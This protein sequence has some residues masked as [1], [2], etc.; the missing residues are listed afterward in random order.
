MECEFIRNFLEPYAAGQASAREA[1][2]V[3]EHVKACPACGRE[4]GWIRGLKA[5][6]RAAPRPAIP[7]DLRAQLMRQARSMAGAARRPAAR[8][9][10]RAAIGF[11][12]ASAF[13]AAAAVL[14]FGHFFSGGAD[15]LSLDEVLTAH[16]RYE[17]TM[18]AADREAIYADLGLGEGKGGD[19]D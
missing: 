16:R 13:A 3:E 12:F 5:S 14:A 8:E 19:D 4:L 7:D 15:E 9:P 6:L 11:G 10:W 18:P 2:L 17:L 1:A